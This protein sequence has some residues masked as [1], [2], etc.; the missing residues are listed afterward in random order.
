M[1]MNRVTRHLASFPWL[2]IIVVQLLLAGCATQPNQTPYLVIP[3]AHGGGKGLAI[4]PDS[5]KLAS[6]GWNGRIRVWILPG[7]EGGWGWQGHRGEVTTLVFLDVDRLLSAG[8]DG[9]L[10]EWSTRG[11]EIRSVDTGSSVLAMAVDGPRQRVLTGHEDG[12]V[13]LWSL[14]ALKP[15]KTLGGHKGSIRAVAFAPAGDRFASAGTKGQVKL[16]GPDG[17]VENLPPPGSDARTLVFTSDGKQLFGAGWFD[18]YRWDLDRREL[19]TLDTDHRGII[20]SIVFDS[21]ETYLASISRITDSSVLMLDP[22]SGETV[23]RFQSHKLCGGSIA[24]APNG[25]I[26]ATTADDASVMIWM[27]E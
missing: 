14:P 9:G 6:A 26:M 20:N 15:I 13:R 12:S 21:T 16:W 8:Y 11:E 4:S 27:L 3:D 1:V 25:R 10:T 24:M 2:M 19:T 5:S 7:G 23:R 17:R 18:L 22:Q